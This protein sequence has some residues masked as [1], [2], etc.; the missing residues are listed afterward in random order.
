MEKREGMSM[1]HSRIVGGLLLANLSVADI[2]V[3]PDTLLKGFVHPPVNFNPRTESD[4]DARKY[5]GIPS[6]FSMSQTIKPF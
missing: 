4:S 1:K 2:P 6:I 5:Q 3:L